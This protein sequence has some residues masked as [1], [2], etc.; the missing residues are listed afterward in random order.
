MRFL[1][2]TTDSACERCASVLKEGELAALV[3]SDV[4]KSEA[5]LHPAC[6]MAISVDSFVRALESTTLTIPDRETLEQRARR[7]QLARQG[8][9]D[10]RWS[11]GEDA[12]GAMIGVAPKRALEDDCVIEPMSDAA[13]RPVV[14]VIVHGGG[15]DARFWRVLRAQRLWASSK[16]E[17]FF[18]EPA[19]GWEVVPGEDPTQPIVAHVYMVDAKKPIERESRLW[20]L[21]VLGAPRPLVLVSGTPPKKLGSASIAA[22]R[23]RLDIA[24]YVGDD[25]PLL[26]VHRV[27]EAALS[28][29]VDG[30]DEHF[31]GGEFRERGHPAQRY[32][33]AMLEDVRTR[34]ARD[35]RGWTSFR[36][37]FAAWGRTER[38]DAKLIELWDELFERGELELCTSLLASRTVYDRAR[39]ARWFEAERSRGGQEPVNA[40]WAVLRWANAQEPQGTFERCLSLLLESTNQRR[41]KILLDALRETA[42]QGAIR[43][44]D[45]TYG[46]AWK[47]GYEPLDTELARWRKR[48]RSQ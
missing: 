46:P 9:R 24:G 5:L 10:A 27:N 21:R 32:A 44:L 13:G 38:S 16:R 31:D 37:N 22:V 42:S 26:S 40:F 14:R 18:I 11:V 23:A 17:Y 34:D 48:H 20:Q 3:A 43:W 33:D 7:R 36:A 8:R 41:Q 35:W 47:S 45:A 15:V 28:A 6:A 2:L 25:C 30:L 1:L 29:L 19:K 4:G 12:L 39:L